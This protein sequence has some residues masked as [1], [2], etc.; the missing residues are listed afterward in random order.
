MKPAIISNLVLFLLITTSAQAVTRL[1]P[2]EYPTIQ[3]A[4]DDCN[5]GDVVVVAPGTYTGDGNRDIDFHGKAIT[6]RSM[7]PND[8]NVVAETVINCQ[9]TFIDT[10]RGFH[11]QSGEEYDSIV[12]GF[13]ITNGYETG[14]SGILFERD[15][16]TPSSPTVQNCI[17]TGNLS[18]GGICCSSSHPRIINCIISNNYGYYSDGL[19]CYQSNPQ[20]INCIISGNRRHGI[21]CGS[22]EPT[23][24]NCTIVHNSGSGIDCLYS[25]SNPT[26]I[27]CVI[28]DNALSNCPLPSY[29]CWPEGTS[30]TGNMNVYPEFVDP[31]AGNYRLLPYS[32]CIDRGT[33]SLPIQLHPIDVDGNQRITDGDRNGSTLIDMG[34][35]EA[36]PSQ[37]PVINLSAE[38][39]HFIAD[40]NSID[41]EDQI[42]IIHN[43]G[44]DILNWIITY[45]CDWLKVTPIAGS[46]TDEMNE[47]T[48]SVDTTGL[49][50]GI[51][52]CTLTVSDRNALNSPETVTVA[53]HLSAEQV[54][55]P[56][57]FSTIQDAINQVLE[58]RT[59]IVADGIYAGPGNCDIDF[60]G[61]AITVRSENGPENC[62]I[63]CQNL[64]RGFYFHSGE[65]NNSVL[66]GFTI[67]NGYAQDKG[68]AITCDNR[69]SPTIRNC[70]I[71]ANV[72][73]KCERS[74][75]NCGSGGIYCCENS[76]P[77]IDS[78]TITNNTADGYNWQ[79]WGG[80]I[81]FE[82]STPIISNCII[83]DNNT[84]SCGGGIRA[85]N[86]SDAIITDCV[87]LNN[88][89]ST[90]GGI[91]SKKTNLIIENC[92]IAGNIAS[93]S[94]GIFSSEGTLRVRNCIITNNEA[95]S[96]GGISCSQ[97]E[98]LLTNCTIAYN[99][100]NLNG[101]GI[102]CG[103]GFGKAILENCI[104]WGN[105][106]E[107]GNQVSLSDCMNIIGCTGIEINHSCIETGP[108]AGFWEGLYEWQL[109]T[110]N[111]GNIEADPHFVDPNNGDFTLLPDSPC[112]DAG[113]NDPS[114]QLP[115]TDLAGTPRPLDGDRDNLAIVDMG[116]YE[117]LPSDQIVIWP[118]PR[119]IEFWATEG[120]VNP[121]DKVLTIRNRGAGALDWTITYDCDWLQVT[122]DTGNSTQE[123]D[124]ITLKVD[125]TNLTVGTHN[126]TLTISSLD[127]VNNPE[128]VVVALHVLGE[129]V[130]V[131]NQFPGIQDAIDHTTDG[132]VV[133]VDDGIYTG[134]GN[135]DIDFKGKAITVCSKNGPKNC[136]IDCQGTMYEPHRG[137]YFHSFEDANSTLDG[138]TITNGY[139]RKGVICC[140]E[141]SPTINNC[142]I[143][144]NHNDGGIYYGEW[145]GPTSTNP[146]ITNCIINSNERF[147]IYCSGKRIYPK[148]SNCTINNNGGWGIY[149]DGSNPSI[150][151]CTIANNI[152]EGINCQYRSDVTI[153]NCIIR[154]NPIIFESNVNAT[155]SYSNIQGGWPGEGNIDV[156]PLFTHDFHLQAG[157]PCINAGDPNY[158]SE[159]GENDID[160]E[161]RK[162]E[163]RVDIGP[164]EFIDTDFDGLPDWWEQ[165]YFDS[166]TAAEPV[167]DPDVDELSNI[168]EYIHSSNPLHPR[169]EFFVNPIEGDNNSDGLTPTWDSQHGPKA[170]IQ[171]AI[172]QVH[173]YEEADVILVPGVYTGLGNRDIDF[174]G[175]SITVRSIDPNDPNVVNSTVIDC[176]GT[177]NEPH[178]AFYFHSGESHSSVVAGLT[179]TNGNSPDGGAIVCYYSSPTIIK[180]VISNNEA[181]I[182]GHGGGIDCYLSNL[183]IKNCIIT[184]NKADY[185]NGAGICS[186][187]SSPTIINCT[188]AGNKADEGGGV[189]GSN[190]TLVNCI[191]WD[192]VPD[193]IGGR[194]NVSYSDIQGGWEGKGNNNI[195]PFFALP[196]YWDSNG[197][198][199]NPIDDFWIEGDYHLNSQAGRWDPVSDSRVVDDVTSPCIDAGDPNSPVGDEPEPNGGRIN[200][201]AYG[202]TVQASISLSKSN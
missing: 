155:V 124:E 148:I 187:D 72:V 9:G 89:A 97:N 55:V 93:T 56:S 74:E 31:S 76:N 196:G 5:D 105:T 40:A 17:I 50:P 121:E 133:I 59:V 175:K 79:S 30:G 120:G 39:F 26:I 80:G 125:T 110:G 64:S 90:G 91:C 137:F 135:R 106:A 149:C 150:S 170:T 158:S 116:A 152:R 181:D 167:D 10:H 193:Q 157:S 115:S 154:D 70:I 171:A 32:P 177:I 173:F 7:D 140:T 143:C 77:S 161:E 113:T 54:H 162:F 34:A 49:T 102:A 42:L 85:D 194:V 201:G 96:G 63:D 99:R 129:V 6:V 47:I 145:T 185:G 202:G 112:I 107:Q 159:P 192:N 182:W 147:G 65:E 41:I 195:E 191:L 44:G 58:G 139:Y 200:M 29:S 35:Y 71:T 14:G 122:P 117:A 22:G 62:I 78:C 164:D 151:N 82:Q 144:R 174:Y 109:E 46:S 163:K 51:Y 190:N 138:F 68:G 119:K 57:Q 127:A 186:F 103:T 142:R 126:C 128:T 160:G 131:P 23:I 100:A 28:W 67:T 13:V 3:E 81:C 168:A 176:A 156:E 178:R 19:Y 18:G 104:L 37:Q 60:K 141:S 198:V 188:F 172:D 130:H 114:G 75:C 16:T 11:F 111:S 146:I 43:R 61:K 48:L 27:N 83:R 73:G 94:G 184:G 136:I 69:S 180:C 118:S 38:Q 20:L 101:G 153:N 33:N 36:I 4:I 66:D 52:T 98:P 88:N 199:D 45:D 8:P 86:S 25:N 53:L 165:K 84:I 189:Y 24:I 123:P 2:D 12:A 95:D 132:G 134:P 1:V 108:N 92:V 169:T 179:I 183:V 166:V 87:I 197:T 15:H 21:L